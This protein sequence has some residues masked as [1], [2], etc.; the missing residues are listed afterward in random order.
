M[1][2]AVHIHMEMVL[3]TDVLFGPIESYSLA[4]ISRF[5]NVWEIPVI[6]PG[7]L[8]EAF[9]KKNSHTVIIFGSF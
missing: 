1:S 7:G 9:S 5:A 3:I 4:Q 8:S 6:S 2:L